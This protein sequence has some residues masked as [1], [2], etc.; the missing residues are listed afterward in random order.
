M[1]G[2]TRPPTRAGSSAATAAASRSF[3]NTG[4]SPSLNSSPCPSAQGNIRMSLNR[5]AASNPYR[6][7][8]CNVTSAARSGVVQSATKSFT[9]DRT[10]RYSG[11]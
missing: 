8:G 7:I 11:R 10:A 4:P 9:P 3:G 2:S 5:I 1:I 6:R